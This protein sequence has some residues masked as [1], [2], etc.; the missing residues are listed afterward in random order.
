MSP[1][2]VYVCVCRA[3]GRDRRKVTR[4]DLRHLLQSEGHVGA[5]GRA[6]LFRPIGILSSSEGD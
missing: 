3:D 4:Y 1:T 6:D 5:P 2:Y